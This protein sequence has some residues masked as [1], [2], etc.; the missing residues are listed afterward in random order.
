MSLYRFVDGEELKGAIQGKAMVWF[1]IPGCPPCRKVSPLAEEV[2]EEH[3]GEAKFI[4]VDV[5]KNTRLPEPYGVT[6][7]PTFLF[8]KGGREVARLEAVPSREEFELAIG[9]LKQCG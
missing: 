1:S 6:S 9:E 4:R 5:E 3:S 8:F 2:A 7:I